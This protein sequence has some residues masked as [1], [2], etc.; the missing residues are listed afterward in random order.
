MKGWENT[1]AAGS[2]YAGWFASIKSSF[3]CSYWVADL[4]QTVMRLVNGKAT[5]NYGGEIL[6]PII[7]LLCAM[8]FL[9][10]N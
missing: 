9:N 1:V 3:M 6:I 5:V 7:I 2:W 8:T 10:S 4:P